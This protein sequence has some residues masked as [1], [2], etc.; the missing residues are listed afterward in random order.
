MSAGQG[1]LSLD[2][3]GALGALVSGFALDDVAGTSTRC[4]GAGSFVPQEAHETDSANTN[5]ETFTT[6]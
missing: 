4:G 2:A 5:V 1:A 3:L 6:K